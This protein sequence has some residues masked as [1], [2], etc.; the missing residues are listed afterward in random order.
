MNARSQGDITTSAT[1]DGKRGS[2]L[3]SIDQS[4]WRS[5]GTYSGGEV[6]GETVNSVMGDNESAW[7]DD[8]DQ[9]DQLDQG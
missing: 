4:T 9:G 7:F 8:Y 3:A 2:P 5:L 6:I 1:H